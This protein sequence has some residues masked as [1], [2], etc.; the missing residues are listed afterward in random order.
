MD[1]VAVYQMN[2]MKKLQAK[3]RRLGRECYG[4]WDLNWVKEKR[5][6]NIDEKK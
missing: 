3:N 2:R 5:R 1:R 6:H 4:T